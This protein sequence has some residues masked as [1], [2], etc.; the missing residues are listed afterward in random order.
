MN[1]DYNKPPLGFNLFTSATRQFGYDVTIM[2]NDNDIKPPTRT[3]NP[4]PETRFSLTVKG[5]L[6]CAEEG[7][8]ARAN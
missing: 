3:S 8:G 5:G 4:Q 7:A 6:K 1:Y 2:D